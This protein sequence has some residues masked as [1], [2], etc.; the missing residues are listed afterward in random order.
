MAGIVR[1]REDRRNGVVNSPARGGGRGG[2]VARRNDR[3]KDRQRRKGAGGG[4]SGSGGS[5]SPTDDWGNEEG[6]YA[7]QTNKDTLSGWNDYWQKQGVKIGGTDAF[8]N[9]FSN[10]A[11]NTALGQWNN[12]RLGAQTT[13]WKNWTDWLGQNG[14]NLRR[15]QSDWRSQTPMTQQLQGGGQARWQFF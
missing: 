12:S 10:D 6:T 9:W 14:Y 8:S 1:R 11:Y 15:L 5:A 3:A 4:K 13:D 7:F 2:G